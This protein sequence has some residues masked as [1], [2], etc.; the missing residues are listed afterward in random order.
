MKIKPIYEN[1]LLKNQADQKIHHLKL[2]NLSKTL[3]NAEIELMK[4]KT[5]EAL[6]KAELGTSRLKSGIDQ[7]ESAVLELFESRGKSD[8]LYR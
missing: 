2:D 5:N 6:K 1:D 8:L 4:V 7:L 3:K